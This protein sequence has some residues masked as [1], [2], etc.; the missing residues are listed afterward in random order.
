MIRSGGHQIGTI[1]FLDNRKPRAISD[2]GAFV[3]KKGNYRM[4]VSSSAVVPIIALMR[5]TPAE[6]LSSF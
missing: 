5:R 1:R 2:A 3:M 4:G 6:E